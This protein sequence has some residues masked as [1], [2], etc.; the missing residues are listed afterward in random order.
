[1]TTSSNNILSERSIRMSQDIA[2]KLIWLFSDKSHMGSLRK[3]LPANPELTPQSK[4]DHGDEE[5]IRTLALMGD[6]DAARALI[7]LFQD[8]LWRET[9]FKIIQALSECPVQRSLEFLFRLARDAG[10]LT[11]AESAIAALGRTRHILAARFLAHFYAECPELLKSAVVGAIGQIPDRTLAEKFVSELAPAVE[12]G[13]IPLVRNLIISL[14]EFKTTAA[15]PQIE[16]LAAT[17]SDSGVRLAALF[18]IGKIART[19]ETLKSLENRFRGDFF[20]YQYFINARTQIQFR[21]QW[22]LEDY[23]MKLFGKAEP[24]PT[25]PYELNHF[26]ADDVKEGLRLFNGPAN[27]ERLCLALSGLCFPGIA[28]W[29]SELI[30]LNQL[31]EPQTVQVLESLSKHHSSHILTALEK[32]RPVAF[33]DTSGRAFL[34][35]FETLS[36]SLPDADIQFARFFAS[37]EASA[38]PESRRIQC[39]NQLVNFGLSVQTVPSRTQGVERILESILASDPSQAVQARALR[40]LGSLQLPSQKAQAF[41]KKMLLDPAVSDSCLFYLENCPKDSCI[42]LLLL[43]L[44]KTGHND[45]RTMALLRTLSAQRSLPEKNNDLDSL[46]RNSLKSSSSEELR[47]ESLRLLEK[48]PRKELLPQILQCLS[49]PDRVA[50]AATVALRSFNDEKIADE[51]APLLT[52]GKE[53]LVGRTLDTLTILP[54]LR[55]KRIVIDFLTRNALDLSLCDKVIRCLKTP[56]TPSPYFGQCISA[57]IDAH[58]EHPLLDGLVSLRDRM[59]SS[60]DEASAAKMGKLRKNADTK[61]LDVSLAKEIPGYEGLDEMVKSTLRSAE[62]PF[63]HPEM[64]DQYVDKSSSVLEYCKAVDMLLE[65]EVGRRMLFVKIEQSLH[66]FQNAIYAAGLNETSASAERVIQLMGL[67]KYF[68]PQS[69]PLHKM[70]TI[71]QNILSGRILHEQFKTLDGLRAW[72]VILLL[73]AR[74]KPLLKL[75]DAT[76]DSVAALAKRLMILQDVRNLAAHRQTFPEFV[77]VDDVRKEVIQLFRILHKVL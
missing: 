50:L 76:S 59:N 2:L 51:L 67:E 8:C 40:G 72:G 46:L 6:A 13:N 75:K 22:K 14:G 9:R 12:S 52:S 48:H 64:F 47:C 54:G 29:Y 20:E 4:M 73:F 41:S 37:P 57:I 42:P 19:P 27:H 11:T 17:S 34:K 35:W 7:R 61:A 45:K 31:D 25:L 15:L 43:L 33:R 56:D 16:K 70:T 68:T 65:R 26:N 49:S 23:L 53:S 69:L 39:I 77:T 21:A 62:V 36:L 5:V 71:S 58:P 30:D 18:S 10:D 44:E 66:E 3:K 32:L 38:M 74:S 63:L 60:A 1:M 55:A 28:T 24:H